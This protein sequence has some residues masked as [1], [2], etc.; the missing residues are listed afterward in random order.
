MASLPSDNIG[1]FNIEVESPTDGKKYN[2]II[3]PIEFRGKSPSEIS[4]LVKEQIARQMRDAGLN[5]SGLKIHI[6]SA[7]EVAAAR[8]AAEMQIGTAA[9][10][11]GDGPSAIEISIQMHEQTI[12]DNIYS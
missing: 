3:E 2:F 1:S 6:R 5:I 8:R 10:P 11:A 4:I 9:A 7:E 12:F